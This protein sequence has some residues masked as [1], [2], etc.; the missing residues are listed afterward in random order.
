MPLNSN[1]SIA[2]R[3]VSC[4]RGTSGEGA[5][6]GHP[7]VKAPGSGELLMKTGHPCCPQNLLPKIIF[8]QYSGENHM[9]LAALIFEA[10]WMATEGW[11]A[12]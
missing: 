3:A 1:D 7:C 9:Q 12:G 2:E 8:A 4:G 6:F 11:S 10:Y 5:A